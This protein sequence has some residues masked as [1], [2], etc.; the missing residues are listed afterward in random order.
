[1]D[2]LGSPCSPEG[3]GSRLEQSLPNQRRFRSLHV[4]TIRF[5]RL[6]QESESGELDLRKAIKILA[7]GQKRRIYDITNV[8]E[9]AGLIKKMS[10]SIVRWIGPA[11]AKNSHEIASRLAVLKSE[12]QDLEY[13]EFTLDQQKLW[14]EQ[15]IRNTT[16]DCSNL[17]YVNHEDI[18]NCFSGNTLLAV[19]APSGTQLDVPIPKAVLNSPAKYQIHLKSTRGP[20]DVVLLNKQSVSSVPVVLPVPPPEE[21]LQ[22]AKSAMSTSHEKES[23]TGPCQASVDTKESI[24]SK[25]TSLKD[26]HPSLTSSFISAE[27][28]RPGESQLRDIS[29]ELQHLIEP[30]KKLLNKDILAQLLASEVFTP[31]FGPPPSEH[32][33]LDENNGLSSLFDLRL[34]NV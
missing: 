23:S 11:P 14:V 3:D 5:V 27:L 2:L 17:T 30:T 33:H 13:V 9:G 26:V 32:K 24:R 28:N 29:E 25:R 1:M 8:L 6:L 20:I 16:E 4:L 31:V 12:L 15:S 18:C 10:K 22:S 19:K 21:F 7:A 34:L